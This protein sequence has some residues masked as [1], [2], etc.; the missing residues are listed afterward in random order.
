MGYG[1]RCKNCGFVFPVDTIYDEK[2]SSEEKKIEELNKAAL[3]TAGVDTSEPEF[4]RVLA[5]KRQNQSIET[6][7]LPNDPD[8]FVN[9]QRWIETP[10]YREIDEPIWTEAMEVLRQI[11]GSGRG[12]EAIVRD[13]AWG[14]FVERYDKER[15]ALIGI[16][17]QSLVSRTRGLSL[18]ENFMLSLDILTQAPFTTSINHLMNSLVIPLIQRSNIYK[19]GSIDSARKQKEKGIATVVLDSDKKPWLNVN[20]KHSELLNRIMEDHSKLIVEASPQARFIANRLGNELSQWIQR[21]KKLIFE[22]SALGFTEKEGGYVLRNMIIRILA[23]I[24]NRSSSLYKDIPKNKKEDESAKV[25]DPSIDTVIKETLEFISENFARAVKITYT[26]T[27]KEIGEILL[28]R[29]EMEKNYIIAEFSKLE[30]EEKAVEKMLKSYGMGKWAM[31]K[32]V[33]DY[34]PELFEHDRNQ[35]ITMGQP[36]IPVAQAPKEGVFT[37]ADFGLNAGLNVVESRADRGYDN[38]DEEGRGYGED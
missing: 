16:L 24:T 25:P 19:V 26:P 28:K 35:R 27:E 21:W 3:D 11:A 30:E 31:G 14:N 38:N 4:E 17:G 10:I 7:R 32:N 22:S 18:A 36:D 20:T 1:N 2:P 15:T 8:L 37:R 6:F 23:D 12:A 34:S 29:S 13:T 9:I 5:V 33:K